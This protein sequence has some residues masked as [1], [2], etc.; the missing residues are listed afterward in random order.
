[1]LPEWD[2]KGDEAKRAAF[3]SWAWAEL[4]RF[5][6]MVSDQDAPPPDRDDWADMLPGA[7]PVPRTVGRPVDEWGGMNA[8][9]WEFGLLRYMFRRYW[10]GKKRRLADSAS[11]ASIAVARCQRAL[12]ADQRTAGRLEA[13]RDLAARVFE[14]WERGSHSPGRARAEADIAILDALPA[15]RFAR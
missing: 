12:P 10:P 13:R 3:I 1:M 9:V 14:E 8:M 15:N 11:A 5:A 2:F 6:L 7:V 4:D